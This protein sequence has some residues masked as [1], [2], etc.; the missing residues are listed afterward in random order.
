MHLIVSCGSGPG[1]SL[2][3]PLRILDSE[4]NMSPSNQSLLRYLPLRAS[5]IQA[6]CG[7]GSPLPGLDLRIVERKCRIVED[8]SC[9]FWTRITPEIPEI[10]MGEYRTVPAVFVFRIV[11]SSM[12]QDL[13][14]INLRKDAR[15]GVLST[16]LQESVRPGDPLL[17]RC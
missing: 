15:I 3:F 11:P 14:K 1:T 9:N 7:P 12:R 10:S 16:P 8:F 2:N 13:Q 4:Q 17:Y 6:R 5:P